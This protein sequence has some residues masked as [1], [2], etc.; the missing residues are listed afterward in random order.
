MALQYRLG[1]FLAASLCLEAAQEGD[2]C[3][4]RD[5]AMDQPGVLLTFDD[6]YVE[7]W[8]AALPLFAK[9][10]AHATFFVTQF[11]KLSD[12][13]I[14]GLRALKR[15]GH[16]IGCHGLRHRKAA[17]YVREHGAAQYLAD[18][19]E[20]ALALMTEAG[21][22]PTC[23]AYPM[24]NRSDESDAA[25]LQHFRHLRGG[26]FAT[27]GQRLVQLDALFTPLDEIAARGCLLGR[28]LDKAGEEGREHVID[29]VKEALQRAK[30]SRECVVF[31]SHC[32]GTEPR[33]HI[34]PA[35]LESILAYAHELGLQFYTYD[36][37]P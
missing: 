10:G 27:E 21:L 4:E 13:Q 20:S 3:V 1:L 17:E 7:A 33:N 36:D 22:V 31:Y 25:L 2:I 28:S 32:I 9:Y 11:D 19:I 6:T 14:H 24:S 35:A 30:Q 26:A 8:V 12:T 34:T 23:F 18:E 16:A 29:E 37:L 5:R 15:A